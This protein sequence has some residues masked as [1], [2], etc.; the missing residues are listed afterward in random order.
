M[1]ADAAAGLA[2]AHS[3][4]FALLQNTQQLHL[5]TVRQL[6][7]LVQKQRALRGQ[8]ETAYAIAH[9]S[10]EGAAHVAKEL[11]FEQI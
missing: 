3:L 8:L 10:G 11:G 9:G 7:D 5:K 2:F 1:R 4:V 6:S